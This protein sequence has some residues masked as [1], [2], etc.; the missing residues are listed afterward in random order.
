[1]IGTNAA[2]IG[3]AIILRV[4]SLVS[5]RNKM[6]APSVS[7]RKRRREESVDVFNYSWQYS[8]HRT[9]PSYALKKSELSSL[10]L[11]LF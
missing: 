2:Y 4:P 10:A 1:M 7:I 3:E 11:S 6:F 8:G 5:L 9:T